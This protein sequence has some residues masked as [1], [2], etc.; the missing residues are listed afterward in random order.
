MNLDMLA[1]A[2][3]EI[4]EEDFWAWEKIRRAVETDLNTGWKIILFLFERAS[5]ENDVHYVAAGPGGLN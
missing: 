3:R 4:D 5:S 2:Y 1:E